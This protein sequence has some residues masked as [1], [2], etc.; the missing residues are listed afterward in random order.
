M[1][2]GESSKRELNKR[3]QSVSVIGFV[4]EGVT[5]V[6]NENEGNGSVEEIG[7]ES[8]FQATDC[9]VQDN[10]R[11]A[12]SLCCLSCSLQRID[13]PLLTSQRYQDGC[14]GEMHS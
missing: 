13:V 5:Y 14:G 8:G 10:W 12:V 11:M 6:Y 2:V 7:E 1:L 9:C 4:R 3:T